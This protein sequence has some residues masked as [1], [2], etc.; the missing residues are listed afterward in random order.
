MPLTLLR[1][2][3]AAASR[4][5]AEA[6]GKDGNEGKVAAA[7]IQ[8]LESSDR[9]HRDGRIG[10]VFHPGQISF[11]ELKEQDSLHIIIK[12][13]QVSAHID[14]VCPLRLRPGGPPSYSWSRVFAHNLSGSAADLG[15]RLRGIHG[16]QRCN[17]GCE[18]VWVDEQIS[19]MA[20]GV[21]KDGSSA[22]SC[23][24]EGPG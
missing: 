15:R 16:Q 2:L 11:R 13:E 14:E 12:G 3:R 6:D 20:A 21:R 18:V 8:A 9:F 24:A 22:P 10:S 17:L 7:L 23:D 5:A 1:R 4:P 19:E